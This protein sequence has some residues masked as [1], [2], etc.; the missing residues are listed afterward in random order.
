MRWQA[1]WKAAE[2]ATAF[3]NFA[4]VHFVQH[5]NGV[6]TNPCCCVNK[7]TLENW[8]QWRKI[9]KR[10]CVN[11]TFTC[12]CIWLYKYMGIYKE[13]RPFN[14]IFG[15]DRILR[16]WYRG[17]KNAGPR[18]RA[19]GRAQDTPYHIISPYHNGIWRIFIECG[20]KP[21]ARKSA[22]GRSARGP[23]L[24]KSNRNFRQPPH[25]YRYISPNIIYISS[26]LNAPQQHYQTV[27]QLLFRH[28]RLERNPTRSYQL[29]AGSRVQVGSIWV[30]PMFGTSWDMF[31]FSKVSYQLESAKF[32]FFFKNKN[33]PFLT[34]SF[35][36]ISRSHCD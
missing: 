4:G 10:A 21:H 5:V 3:S 26:N 14:H 28:V 20:K 35:E 13:P 27:K 6:Y 29:Q 2:I 30:L 34:G 19:Q 11:P 8:I 7:K 23:I 18:K 12:L 24:P 32:L 9:A 17:I 1:Q 15:G 16:A 31:V 22:Q 36:R 25:M 33:M